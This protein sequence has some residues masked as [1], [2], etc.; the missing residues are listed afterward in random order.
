[1]S[2]SG[3]VR[4]NGSA[5]NT[6]TVKDYGSLSFFA[7]TRKDQAPWTLVHDTVNRLSIE[8]EGGRWDGPVRIEKPLNVRAESLSGGTYYSPMLELYGPVSGDKGIQLVVD[9]PEKATG[10]LYL[11]STNNSFTGGINLGENTYLH[12]MADGVVPVSGAPITMT[13]AFVD[14][15]ANSCKLPSV[16]CFCSSLRTISSDG[17]LL[18]GR[19]VGTFT[20]RG[21][22]TLDYEWQSG[23]GGIDLKEGTLKL[24]N[25]QTAWYAGVY[26]G[27]MVQGWSSGDPTGSQV[28]YSNTITIHDK[29]QTSFRWLQSPMTFAGGGC[30]IYEGW[31]YCSPS[32]AGKWRFASN[33]I[34]LGR[35]R[36]DDAHVI[37]RQNNDAVCFATADITEGWHKIEFRMGRTSVNGGPNTTVAKAYERDGDASH[38]IT[39]SLAEGML[40]A[41]KNSGIGLAVCKDSEKAEA[42]TTDIADFVA[43]PD[44][45]GDGSVL[46]IA[47]PGSA[48]E[49][50]LEAEYIAQ[51]TV[52]SLTSTT[53][54]VLD[55]CGAPLFVGC[56][57]GFPT[58]V[59]TSIPV[60]L[61]GSTPNLTVTND[62]TASAAEIAAGAVFSVT[63]GTLTFAEGATFTVPDLHSLRNT[64][65]GCFTVA[66]ATGGIVGMPTL[67]FEEGDRR[68][69][70]HKSPDGKSLQ[71]TVSSGLMI[72]FR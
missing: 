64:Q 60:W 15:Q 29:V 46:R 23:M 24:S 10:H 45:P 41:W 5:D 16:D 27:D 31:F 14:V 55:L 40:A 61:A 39:S 70:L 28:W 2:L 67:V 37:A 63:D 72:I 57:T 53:N 59:N 4:L 71:L 20:K 30:T 58:V 17:G 69:I 7:M 48:E 12:V 8:R 25:A 13:N 21:S 52:G 1:M 33:V 43:F 34:Y 3:T 35:L 38:E 22:G 50:A 47:K 66:T 56:V 9:L 49:A 19:I 6:I 11:Y 54:A 65:D 68:G 44:D 26:E 36:V 62:W 42:G 32:Q 51:R 18:P